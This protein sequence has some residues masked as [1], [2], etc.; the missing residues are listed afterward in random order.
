[1]LE[2]HSVAVID[3]EVDLVEL[4]SEALKLEGYIV[5]G[6]DS[7]LTA[8]EHLYKNHS[9]FCLVLTDVRMPG[10]DGFQVA[11]LVNQLD[12]EIKIIC[13]SAFEMYDKEVD[14][15]P[16]HEFLKKPIHIP[17]LI[18]AIKKHLVPVK[19]N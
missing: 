2:R 18:E 7:P 10:M 15:V 4:F 17:Q 19:Y 11:K 16:M 14:E 8:L 3:D 12:N 13:M 6:F 5:R 9:E 1:M